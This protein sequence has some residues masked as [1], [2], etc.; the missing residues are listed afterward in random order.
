MA[1]TI[2]AVPNRAGEPAI[3]LREAWREARRVRK[4]TVAILSR[5]PPGIVEGFRDRSRRP[6]TS[7]RS[8]ADD[9]EDD[10]DNDAW[11]RDSPAFAQCC[12]RP[13]HRVTER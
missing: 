1:F 10:S 8:R 7:V 9:D 3:L 6:R 12:H 5:G 13:H 2:E 11:P 4:R